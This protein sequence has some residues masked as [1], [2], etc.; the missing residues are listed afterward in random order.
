[1]GERALVTTSV[2]TPT[3]SNATGCLGAL[4]L[5]PLVAAGVNLF[6]GDQIPRELEGTTPWFV[7]VGV[8]FGAVTLIVW[9]KNR[10][11][12]ELIER[13]GELELRIGDDVYR[14]PFTVDYAYLME[15]LKGVPMCHLTLHVYRAEDD[16]HVVCLQETWGAIHGRPE[17]WVQDLRAPRGAPGPAWQAAAGRFVDDVRRAI[18][19]RA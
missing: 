16:A 5:I 6:A 11:S 1:M 10:R 17:G 7:L 3:A 19:D 15:R 2:Q 13:D 4:A 14:G 8:L 9:N 18:E 12:L